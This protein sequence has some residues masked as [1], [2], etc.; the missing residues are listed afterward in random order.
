MNNCISINR[1]GLCNNSYLNQN[2]T[3]CCIRRDINNYNS[4]NNCCNPC[5]Y[6]LPPIVVV[7]TGPGPIASSAVIEGIRQRLNNGIFY[8]NIILINSQ[9]DTIKLGTA[10][11]SIELAPNK[12]Y[13][14][15]LETDTTLEGAVPGSVGAFLSLNGAR[16]P[17][18][19]SDVT[20]VQPGIPTV[21]QTSGEL[22]TGNNPGN[23]LMVFRTSAAA[24]GVS[25][26][27]LTI[28]E[29]LP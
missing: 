28:T 23:L 3:D 11:G 9:G 17:G 16:V 20:N 12:T 19:G 5:C 22:T 26:A 1:F 14:Y 15:T 10:P 13:K 24:G 2:R 7:I 8:T 4:F 27:K 29:V 6:S 21:F 25:S 18:T